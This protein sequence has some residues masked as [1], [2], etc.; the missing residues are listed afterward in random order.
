[1]AECFSTASLIQPIIV[2]IIIL[3]YAANTIIT[4]H[5]SITSYCN[6]IAD[7]LRITPSWINYLFPWYD[8]AVINPNKSNPYSMQCFFLKFK[9]FA[10]SVK[11]P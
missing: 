2:G 5:N 7:Q 10:V 4:C 3:Q 1:M 11:D 6:M 9:I 8:L